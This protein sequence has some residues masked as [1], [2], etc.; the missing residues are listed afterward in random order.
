VG[1]VGER[2]ITVCLCGR[3]KNPRLSGE[4]KS[5]TQARLGKVHRYLANTEPTEF[6][7]ELSSPSGK[8]NASR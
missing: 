2:T 4:G 1:E 8:F 7:E 6:A 3:S 5:T